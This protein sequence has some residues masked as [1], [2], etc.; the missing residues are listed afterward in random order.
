MPKNE[1]NEFDWMPW[2]PL[3]VGVFCCV[4]GFAAHFW[5][6]FVSAAIYAGGTVYMLL[7]RARKRSK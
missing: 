3:G 6:A 4:F 5:P 2:A 1:G 7:E